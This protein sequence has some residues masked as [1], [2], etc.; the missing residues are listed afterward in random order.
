MKIED[1]IPDSQLKMT[2]KL[3]F[4][5][6]LVIGISFLVILILVLNY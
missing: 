6:A 3:S 2:L 5:N 4:R 1:E